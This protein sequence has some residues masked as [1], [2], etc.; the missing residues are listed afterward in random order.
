[1]SSTHSEHDVP[2]SGF[3]AFQAGRPDSPEASRWFLRTASRPQAPLVL[4]CLPHAGGAASAFR[5]WH[6]V[7]PDW[8]D[9]AAVRLPG[10]ESRIAEGPEFRVDEVAHAITEDSGGRPFA[11]FGHSMGGR[12]AFELGRLLDGAAPLRHV[13]ISGIGHPAI[14]QAP[15]DISGLADADLVDWLTSQGAVPLP[16]LANDQY[17]T[18]LLRTV[19]S[20][21]R[22]LERCSYV[23]APP[24]TCGMTAYAGDSDL[25]APA[26][27]VAAWARET[28]GGFTARSYP[29]GHFYLL[30]H[31]P[32]V[33]ADLTTDLQGYRPAPQARTRSTSRLGPARGS[34]VQAREPGSH[35][36]GDRFGQCR[37][38]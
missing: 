35:T 11:V 31:L 16:A 20:D 22:W 14:M 24:L 13:M 7:L 19:R 9:I 18:L 33:L 10:R 27:A 28:A 25:A 12:L 26:H 1:M 32:T 30:D 29:G 17:R 38:D 8:I 37:P 5:A 3:G 23:P 6:S 4:Y 34:D 36:G 21:C 15:P 2:P